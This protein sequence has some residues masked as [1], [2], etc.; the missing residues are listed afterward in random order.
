M[1]GGGRLS[2]AVLCLAAGLGP[3]METAR[4]MI[5]L[6]TDDPAHN[7]T[8][9]AGELAGSGWQWQ[10]NWRGSVG[11]PVAPRWFL[12]ARHLG[13]SVGEPF[14]FAGQTYRTIGVVRDP[15]SDLALWQVCGEFPT[16]APLYGG[17]DE[18][19]RVCVLFGRGLGR[20]EPLLATNDAGEAVLRGWRWGHGAGPLRW[21]LN[22]V[23][24]LHP[25]AGRPDTV[26]SGTFDADGGPEEAMLTGGDSGGGLFIHRDG[27]WELAGVALAVD[28]PFRLTPEGEDIHAAVFDAGGLYVEQDGTWEIVPWES[29]PQPASFYVTRIAARR[30]WIE[31]TLAAHAAAEEAP[32]LETASA[33]NG[34]FAPVPAVVDA[35]TRSFRLVLPDRPAF[36]RLT[37]CHATRLL[38]IEIREGELILRYG[39][40]ARADSSALET[41]PPFRT[42]DLGYSP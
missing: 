34:P 35:E 37:G 33:V 9:P 41:D 39:A 18:V 5:F 26:L 11:T 25:Y 22:Q 17:E 7:T 13:G 32:V 4:P 16:F 42:H 8:E 14:H 21:G 2:R 24:A 6:A 20:G 10:G 15:N 30:A 23:A 19:G 38:S 36:Y 31:A 12:T 40:A 27:R 1:T 28:S 29:G 3:M